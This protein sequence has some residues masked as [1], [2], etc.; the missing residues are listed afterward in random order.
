MVRMLTHSLIDRLMDDDPSAAVDRLES[1]EESFMRLK[2][3]LRRD[4]ESLLNTT[5]PWLPATGRYGGLED[6][7]LAYGIPDMSTEDMSVPAVR[8][9]TRMTIAQVIARHEPRLSNVEVEVD[10]TLGARGLRLR[11]AAVL[12]ILQSEEPIV[13]EAKVRPGDRAI[14]VALPA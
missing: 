14:D 12:T 6:T 3:A 1:E 13:F 7:I 9:R 4:L 5:R 8:E 10:E 2:V 11:I